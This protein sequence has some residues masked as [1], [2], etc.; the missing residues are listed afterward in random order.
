VV[1]TYWR[2]GDR[3]QLD[4]ANDG[5][6]SK[7]TAAELAWW[8]RHGQ[9]LVDTM[10]AD[11]GPDVMAWLKDGVAYSVHGDH[12]SG[13]ENDQRVPMIIWSPRIQGEKPS[14]AFRTVDILPTVLKA[15][16]IPQD[17]PTDGK[18]F[19]LKFR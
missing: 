11:N 13:K 9:A 8:S 2:D 3:F 14:Y 15:M 6:H 1:A 18:P 7:M 17:K 4:V 5:T 16:N 12:G 10:A 19:T